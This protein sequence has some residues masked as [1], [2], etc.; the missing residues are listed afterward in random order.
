MK[1]ETYSLNDWPFSSHFVIQFPFP[2]DEREVLNNALSS[3]DGSVFEQQLNH[4][5]EK[6]P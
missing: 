1:V 6:N 3:V 2:L 5:R 4:P